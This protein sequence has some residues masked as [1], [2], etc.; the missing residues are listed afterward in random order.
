MGKG[1]TG[2]VKRARATGAKVGTFEA[3]REYL[4]LRSLD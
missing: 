4:L 2:L 3:R 1:I